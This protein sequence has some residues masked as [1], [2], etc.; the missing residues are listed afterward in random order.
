MRD[1]SWTSFWPFLALPLASPGKSLPAFAWPLSVA[2]DGLDFARSDR[3][4]AANTSILASV[5]VVLS[6]VLATHAPGCSSQLFAA[7]FG[8]FGLD[9]AVLG[10]IDCATDFRS[11]R[12]SFFPSLEDARISKKLAKHRPC[13][14][15]SMFGDN[16]TLGVRR[17]LRAQKGSKTYRKNIGKSIAQRTTDG[18]RN[19]RKI[20]ENHRK[21]RAHI[22]AKTVPRA[23]FVTKQSR[24]VPKASEDCP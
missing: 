14:Q 1:P 10:V 24:G 9:L 20:T 22:D 19:D 8:C 4:W 11:L 23:S 7:R 16:R 12:P 21:K 15:K 2:S 3:P 6:N 17:R 13:A 5:T 18:L